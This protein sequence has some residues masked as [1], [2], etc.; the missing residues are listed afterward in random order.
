[1]SLRLPRSNK[2]LHE[3]GGRALA[4]G[5]VLC[6]RRLVKLMRSANA[7]LLW[8]IR[9]ACLCGPELY[10]RR[11]SLST[12]RGMIMRHL[13]IYLALVAVMSGCGSEPPNASAVAGTE[14]W[15]VDTA[16]LVVIGQIQGPPELLFGSVTS[17]HLSTEGE[18]VVADGQNH[19]IKIFDLNGRFVRQF[20]R[21]GRGPAEFEVISGMWLSSDTVQVFDHRLARISRFALSGNYLGNV[22]LEGRG[23]YYVGAFADGGVVLTLGGAFVD[24]DQ[25]N[26]LPTESAIVLYRSDGRYLGEITTVAGQWWYI[27]TSGGGSGGLPPGPTGVPTGLGGV[28]ALS[29]NSMPVIHGDTMYL[30]DQLEPAVN[31]LAKNGETVRTIPLPHGEISEDQARTM[32][33]E[34][35]EEIG[36]ERAARVQFMPRL[37]RIPQ[38]FGLLVD[39]GGLIWTRRYDPRRDHSRTYGFSRRRAKGGEWWV[40]DRAGDIRATI[41]IS[42][43]FAPMEV[44]DSLMVGVSVDSNDVERIVVYRLQRGR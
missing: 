26:V 16:A 36:D 20:G 37:E 22:Q 17:V 38:V 42:D 15:V 18:I 39:S 28:H 23:G 32:V 4:R 34:A 25:P 27:A 43:D 29:P 3:T 33:R 10:V 2:R 5:K 21:S 19:S 35:L 7:R 9:L 24:S 30:L 40:V 41:D 8:L 11:P 14:R 44:N 1:M 12:F 13:H 31:V 6:S